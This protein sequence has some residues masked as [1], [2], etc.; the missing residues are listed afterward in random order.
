MEVSFNTLVP[1]DLDD[2]L[3]I[4]Y[5]CFPT[6]W[7]M[8]AF[9]HEIEFEK[10]IFKT[11]KIGGQLVGYGGFW[12]VLDEIHISNIAI[13]PDYQRRGLGT[14]LLTHLLEEAAARGA[15]KASLEVRR[16]NI[17]AQRLYEGFG[18][19]IVTL[20]KNYYA[21]EH[22]DALVMWNDDIP[23]TLSG[24]RDRKTQ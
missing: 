4:E 24:S 20:R 7:S 15:L 11:L 14:M 19:R 22:E 1:S 3:K 6:P 16:S 9:L 10:S 2:I 18:F 23:A 5:L 12:H 21:D 17:A 13:H 8:A